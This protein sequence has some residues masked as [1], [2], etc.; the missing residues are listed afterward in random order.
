MRVKGLKASKNG[1]VD[2]W[3]FSGFKKLR[4]ISVLNQILLTCYKL[5]LITKYNILHLFFR[6]TLIY[7]Y[8]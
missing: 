6:N 7:F 4:N 2:F 3:S 1:N 8:T 5:Q